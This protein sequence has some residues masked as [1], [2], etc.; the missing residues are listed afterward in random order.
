MSNELAIAGVTA[1]LQ[2]YLNNLYVSV[3]DHFA[4][5]VKVSCLAP[6]QVQ[7][8]ITAAGK[9]DIENQVNLF[10]HQVSFNGA[11]RNVDYASMSKDGTQ[12][13]KN[14]PL[15]LDLHYLLTA[16][17]SEYW[18]S[19]ALLGYAL[20]MLH[21]APMLTRADISN[22]I[23]VLTTSPLP[24]PSN[25]LSGFLQTC[26]LADQIEMIKITPESLSR[27]E[28]AWLWTALKADYR[29]TFPFQV[30]VVLM[31][32]A[33]SH[34]FALPVLA[35]VFS[36]IPMQPPSI[37]ALQTPS[38][39]AGAMPGDLVTVIGESLAGASRVSI[40]NARYGIQMFAPVAA[41]SNSLTFKLPP[42]IPNPYPAGVYQL[43]VQ[44]M[45][46]TNSFAS[47]STNLLPLAVA[48]SLPPTQAAP[49]AATGTGVA[50]TLN[51][52]SPAAR[53][54][55]T[56]VLA[57]STLGTPLT[58]VSAIAQ[59]FTGNVTSLTFDFDQPLPTG[60]NLL[61]RLFVDGVSSAVGA[62]LTTNP[63]TYTG[64][65]VTL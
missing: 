57:L 64:P 29:P 54:G 6:D 40:T 55:Q 44:F 13:L 39:H 31:Q 19:E 65:L 30:S 3:A 33:L 22:A 32:P 52:F 23:S 51:S 2:Y 1:V 61:A 35:R 42:E 26:Q 10:L 50:V 58:S 5:L 60:V 48:P 12:R 36:P 63:P 17:G 25:K 7:N 43:S 9:D 34:S 53:E 21:E 28:M 41:S 16:Y 18:Q 11:W 47:A 45:D 20:M 56:I 27:A 8:E 14:P 59:P 38:G 15:A 37:S 24:Y 62:D 4:S 49:S 46:T